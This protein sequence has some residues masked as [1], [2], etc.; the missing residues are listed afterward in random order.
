[1]IETRLNVCDLNAI[2]T[3]MGAW[4]AECKPLMDVFVPYTDSTGRFHRNGKDPYCAFGIKLYPQWG[5]YENLFMSKEGANGKERKGEAKRHRQIAK[6]AVLGS[7]YRMSGGVWGPGKASYIDHAPECQEQ[8]KKKPRCGCPKIFDRVRTG[9]W[10]YAYGM[11][12]DM[13]QNEAHMA[14]DI[15]RQSYQEI[16]GNGYDGQPKGIWVRLEDAVMEVMRGGPCVTRTFGPNGCFLFDKLNITGRNPIL[17]MH[18]PSGRR[19]HYMDASIKDARMPWTDKEGKAVYRPALHYYQVD[20]HNNW[21]E[22]HTHGGK[23]FENAVQAASRDI[24]A[25]K[26]M[27]FEKIDLPVHGHVHDE[28]ITITRNDPFSLGIKE[29]VDI[30]SAPVDWAPGLLLGA[31]GFEGS[32]YHK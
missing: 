15:F 11:G 4:I 22:V 14:T 10:G 26:L 29:M 7:I 12:V 3:R 5:S 18:L 13:S 24:L 1:M 20:D 28:G 21:S 17:R 27:E 31:D 23:T 8:G 9:L 2:E 19:L 6:P 30:M 32:F 16:C 25:V